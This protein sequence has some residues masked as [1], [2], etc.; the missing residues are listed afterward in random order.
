MVTRHYRLATEAGPHLVGKE[1]VKATSTPELVS[2]AYR[3][4]QA[5]LSEQ[6]SPRPV[7]RIWEHWRKL[8]HFSFSL[9]L[10]TMLFLLCP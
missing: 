8:S 6:I 9:V 3:V 10:L 1:L 4:V 7:S 2:K 5:F